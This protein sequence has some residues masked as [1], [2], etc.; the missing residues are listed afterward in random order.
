M[1]HSQTIDV[2]GTYHL[3][4]LRMR[5]Q[6]GKCRLLNGMLKIQVNGRP[7][8]RITSFTRLRR[9]KMIKWIKKQLK[10]YTDWLFKDFY[11]D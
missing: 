4:Q 8:I 3:S 6:I 11:K 9:K 5:Y 1:Q 7:K 10:K 2:Y